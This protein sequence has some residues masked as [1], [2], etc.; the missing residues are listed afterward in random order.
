M[1]VNPL[2]RIII[3]VIILILI[4]GVFYLGN[5]SG[6]GQDLGSSVSILPDEPS[7]V[8]SDEVG[9]DYTAIKK[10]ITA[11]LESEGVAEGIDFY[12]DV[13]LKEVSG[14]LV[15]GVLVDDKELSLCGVLVS[16]RY[17][18]HADDLGVPEEYK[19]YSYHDHLLELISGV[20]VSNPEFWHLE[21]RDISFTIQAAGGPRGGL[22]GHV[23]LDDSA[24][25]VMIMESRYL[26]NESDAYEIEVFVSDW[27]AISSF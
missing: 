26:V 18:V 16:M 8:V 14:H 4:G 9:C 24:Q 25:K 27:V 15:E 11:R 6:R 23:V 2:V 19:P 5:S 20:E 22:Q 21:L 12:S 13:S 3:A 1:S 10:V 7:G 17:S